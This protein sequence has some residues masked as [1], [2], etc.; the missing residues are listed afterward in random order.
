MDSLR[1]ASAVL[2]YLLGTLTII[3]IVLVHR[4]LY[5]EPMSSFLSVVDLPLLLSGMLFGGSTLAAS[6]ARGKSSTALT[7]AVFIP[8]LIAFGFF[9]WMNFG[10]SFLEL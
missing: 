7:F 8:F 3:A 4:A 1:K 6:L 2:F 5:V 9:A 10:V